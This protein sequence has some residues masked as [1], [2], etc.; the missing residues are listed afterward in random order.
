MNRK[1]SLKTLQG[2]IFRECFPGTHYATEGASHEL[3][4]TQLSQLPC[5]V[6]E[7]TFRDFL[8]GPQQETQ[9]LKCPRLKSQSQFSTLEVLS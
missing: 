4:V 2:F 9:L 1:Y 5:P 3:V 7:T 8:W 6:P